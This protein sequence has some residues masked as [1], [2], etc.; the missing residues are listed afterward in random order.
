MRILVEPL[1]PSLSAS[2]LFACLSEEKEIAFLDSN[3]GYGVLGRWSIIAIRPWLR[4]RGWT[5]HCLLNDER[6]ERD[7]FATLH[8]LLKR[9]P[10]E[11]STASPAHLPLLGG[12]I[13]AIAYD[14][15]FALNDLPL[16]ERVDRS[17]PLVR[18]DFYDLFVLI[19]HQTEETWLMACGQLEPGEDGLARLR[20]ILGS[21]Q[22]RQPDHDH[23]HFA[24]Q[25]REIAPEHEIAPD[26]DLSGPRVGKLLHIPPRLPYMA[27][28][29]QLR[30]WIRLGEVY[31]ANLTGRFKA[32]SPLGS[33]E[34]Y[35]QFRRINPTPF[36]AFIRQEDIEW[37]S[38][39]PERFF[40]IRLTDQGRRVETRPIKGTRPRGKDPVQDLANRQELED[41]GKD[42]SELLMIVDLERNDLSRVCQPTSVRVDEL[43]ALETF[44]EVFHLVSTISG[45]LRDDVDAVACMQACFPG[46]SITGAPKMRSM[47]LIERLED[48]AR[49]FYTGC[50][51]YFSADGQADF[52]II[53]RTM[54]RQDDLILYGAGGGITWESES[55][56]EYQEI[57]DKASYF[58]KLVEYDPIG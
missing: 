45:L 20:Q 8:D 14:A 21:R 28:V 38:A 46:G 18:F 23:D 13:G 10:A 1:I 56:A 34:L 5:D 35:A 43:F 39:S 41:S 6:I 42:R 47:E 55:A 44:P 11:K 57:L 40:S 26:R 22:G 37:L 48:D 16:P 30:E 25:E 4:L 9:Y 49:G 15:G 3:Q 33:T 53:I 32:W 24:L 27:K 17:R 36:A 2:A 29:D 7:P 12:C 19:D 54:V 31:I 50:L 51:G 58:R 52:S